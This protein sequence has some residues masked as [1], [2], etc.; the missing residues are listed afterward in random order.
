M[1]STK[2]L[3]FYQ[4]I[5]KWI[6]RGGLFRN[7]Q[8]CRTGVTKWARLH[9]VIPQPQLALSSE[10]SQQ[11][12]QPATSE[13][14][15]A[16]ENLRS[17]K[18]LLQ[19]HLINSWLKQRFKSWPA[20]HHRF[21]FKWTPGAPGSTAYWIILPALASRAVTSDSPQFPKCGTKIFVCA[22]SKISG[23]LAKRLWQ[24]QLDRFNLHLS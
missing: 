24:H 14:S 16:L 15:A 18:Q 20:Q 3:Q 22:R 17:N 19:L 21:A 8:F 4:P 5:N 6:G 23:C 1:D 7:F 11:L 12:A 9:T 10:P 13:G 2:F